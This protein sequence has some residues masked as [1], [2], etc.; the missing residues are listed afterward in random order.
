MLQLFE[1]ELGDVL[2]GGRAGHEGDARALLEAVAV[3]GANHPQRRFR[4]AMLEA[5]VMLFA[6]APDR[7]V[8]PFGQRVDHRDADAVQSA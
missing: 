1:I 2:E 7:E 3:G 8:Q 6:V 5:H 4:I